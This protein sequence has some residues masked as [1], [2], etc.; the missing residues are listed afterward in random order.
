MHQVHTGSG[1]SPGLSLALAA[2]TRTDARWA[3]RTPRPNLPPRA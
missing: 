1:A 3:S 2:A